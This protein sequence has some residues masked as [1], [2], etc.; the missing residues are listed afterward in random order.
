MVRHHAALAFC[1]R[2]RVSHAGRPTQRKSLCLD[3]LRDPVSPERVRSPYS[4]FV[5]ARSCSG[6]R[7]FESFLHTWS[8]DTCQARTRVPRALVV[9]LSQVFVCGNLWYGLSPQPMSH[10]RRA[11]MAISFKGAHCPQDIMLM[12][13]RWYVAYPLSTRH[14][15][16]RMHERGVRVDH[17][18]IKWIF[19]SPSSGTGRRRSAFSS[20]RSTATACRRSSSSTGVPRMQRP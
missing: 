5:Y 4:T 8:A 15:E 9:V 3:A 16:E 19:C 17:S 20:K 14:V 10:R 6:D 12:G 13:I 7:D 2:T 1:R 18:T 11:T